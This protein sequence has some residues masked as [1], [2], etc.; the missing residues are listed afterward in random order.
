MI[1]SFILQTDWNKSYCFIFSW[2][3]EKE[4]VGLPYGP[5]A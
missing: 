4:E 1:G 5:V 3:I 2:T